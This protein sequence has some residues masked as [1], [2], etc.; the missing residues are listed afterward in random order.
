MFFEVRKKEGLKKLKFNTAC[1]WPNLNAG[2]PRH[3]RWAA[4]LSFPF[5][6]CYFSIWGSKKKSK[7][8][9]MHEIIRR[10]Q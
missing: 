8:R 5:F 9:M 6:F 3:V 1:A 7:K 10:T 4:C 2:E